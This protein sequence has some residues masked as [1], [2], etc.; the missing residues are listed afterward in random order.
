MANF[1]KMAP[2]RPQPSS[3]NHPLS[4]AQL[5]RWAAAGLEG[6]LAAGLRAPLD[7]DAVLPLL[8]TL[9]FNSEAL[10]HRISAR[11]YV[12]NIVWQYFRDFPPEPEWGYVRWLERN[13]SSVGPV[14]VDGA[15]RY[16]LD[17]LF[18]SRL[19]PK[20]ATTRGEARVQRLVDAGRQ[21][22]GEGLCSVRVCLFNESANS[23]EVEP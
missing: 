22:L 2:P 13:G 9:S 15:Q 20:R 17:A 4:D 7:T 1:R 10:S 18:I 11:A 16:R 21:Q 6:V 3:G 12:R 14:W 23:F 8:A 19:L 5:A